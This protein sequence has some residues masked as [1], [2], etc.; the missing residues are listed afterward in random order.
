M[1]AP[2]EPL[3]LDV[4]NTPYSN[5]SDVAANILF[6]VIIAGSLATCLA[7][8]W[9]TQRYIPISLV[10]CIAYILEIV[11]YALRLQSWFIVSYTTNYGLSLIAP[12]FITI[13]IHLCTAEVI[14]ALGTEHA[15]LSPN[16]HLRVFIWT[17]LLA[18]LLQAV[19]LGLTFSLARQAGPWGITLPAQAGPGQAV[20]YA[21]LLLQTLTL[22]SALCLLVVAYIRAGKADRKYG[23]TTFHHGGIGYVRLS[24]K[25][26]TFLVVLP[27]AGV[28]TL[29]RCV[30]K[31]TAAWGGLGSAIARDEVLW[32]AA[33]G[34]MLTEAM[35]SLAVFHPAI[36]LDDYTNERTHSGDV[37]QGGDPGSKLAKRLTVGTFA[38]EMTEPG[39]RDSRQNLEEVSQVLF[40]TDLMARSDASSMG[41]ASRR[42][43][44][45][46]GEHE[47]LYQT[48]PYGSPDARRYS[49]DITSE[50]RG[51]S[52]LEEEAES[53]RQEA[54]SFIEPPRKSSKRISRMLQLQQ[55]Q[56]RE[57]AMEEE[58]RLEVESVVLPSRK[59]SRRDTVRRRDDEMEDVALTST[60][61]QSVY[62]Q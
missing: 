38:T 13:S 2:S 53:H 62:S 56:Q 5:G 61:S 6:L 26:K 22:A 47:Q 17:D 39:N 48:S 41:S 55:Q 50:S 34:V 7:V 4:Y 20:I 21:G 36:W 40:S 11:A 25:L 24:P 52:P 8:T 58:D 44:D 42:G 27:L 59:P 16:A 30:Y 1:A 14:T 18:G 49:E 46:E 28:C 60:Y 31:S 43:S 19:G 51:L 9:K 15:V 10:L 12:V 32:L 33:E 3:W 29:V 37:E 54:E 23:Y 57:A 35:V 45:G